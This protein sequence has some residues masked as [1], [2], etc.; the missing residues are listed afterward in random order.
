[1]F[2]KNA[3]KEWGNYLGAAEAPADFEQFWQAGKEEVQ[4]L[5]TGFNVT[6]VD[7][8]SNLV[9]AYELSFNGVN[10]GTIFCQLLQPKKIDKPL[11][12]VLQFHGYHYSSGDWGDKVSLAAEGVIILAMDVR[13]QGGK[14]SDRRETLGGTD[15][16]HIVLG[17]DEGPQN[18]FYRS[19]YLDAY[20]LAQIALGMPGVDP[21]KLY[22][23]GG[24]QGGAIG[25][26]CASLEPKI[27]KAFLQFPFL[28]DFQGVYEAGVEGSA[29]H[30][31]CE[32][33][34][35]KDP[36]HEREEELFETINYIDVQHFA[37]KVQ[38]KVTWGIGLKDTLVP[39]QGQF[40]A[41]NKLTCEKELLV[42]PD[43]GHEY[44]PK[45]NDRI[46][47]E[48]IVLEN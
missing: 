26:V 45:F 30:E 47:G 1:M 11:P 14:S 34:K 18:L 35:T 4:Q 36:L 48:I 25:L 22:V 43:L 46:R 20:Q 41:Y 29:F 9:D 8:P 6:K 24:S 42:Y 21:E 27:S 2:K 44:L 16:G 32:W 15:I 12:T 7:L 40:A 17:L 23:Y 3:L 33:F 31:L 28:S 39:V 13:G 19:I 10:G 38:A 5:G 37:S